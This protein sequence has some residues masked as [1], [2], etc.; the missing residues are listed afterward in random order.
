MSNNCQR[1]VYEGCELRLLPGA[2]LREHLL[3]LAARCSQ[4]YAHCIRSGLETV[5]LRN[6]YRHVRFTIGKIESVPQRI[7]GRVVGPIWV[8]YKDNTPHELKSRIKVTNRPE[9]KSNKQERPD[10]NITTDRQEALLS[11]R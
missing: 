1:P 6:S 4:R 8:Y 11:C 5:P 2:G 10:I 7:D 3:E 9:R